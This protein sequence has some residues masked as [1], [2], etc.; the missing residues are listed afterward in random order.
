MHLHMLYRAAAIAGL[1]ALACGGPASAAGAVP[2]RFA[3][4]SNLDHVWTMTA[5]ALVFL[6]QAGFMLLEAGHVRS[7]NSI[8]VAQKNLMDFILSSLAFGAVGFA[9]MFGTSQGG[10]FGWDWNLALFGAPDTWG[11]TFFVFQM[12][13]AGTAATI[14]SGAVAERMTLSGYLWC[15]VLIGLFIY[16]VAGHWSWGGLLSGDEAPFLASWGFMDFAGSTV[17]HSV[18]AWVGLAAIIIIGPRTGKFDEEGRP[19]HL[20]GHSPILS[21]AGCVVLWVGWIGFNGGSTTA[22]TDAFAQIVMNTM[23]AGACGGVI[24]MATGRISRGLYRPEASINGVLGGLVGITAGCDAVSAQGAMAIGLSAG[25]VVVAATWLLENV[26]RLDDPLGAIPVHGFAGAWGTVMTGVFARP[27]AL[28]ADSR[29]E[30]VGVQLVGVG[31]VFAFAFGTAF[32][33][34]KMIDILAGIGPEGGSGLRVSARA[35]VEGLNVTE[36]GALV[37]TTVMQRVLA[38]MAN[39][40]DAEFWPLDID[41]GDE[42]YEMSRHFNQ[43][44]AQ[45]LERREG[46]ANRY[47]EQRGER[48]KV[49]AEIA[50]VVAAAAKGDFDTRLELEGKDGFLLEIARDV[51]ALCDAMSESLTQVH[52][53]LAAAARGDFSTRL[54]G[55]Y[56]GSLEIIQS[57]AN[58][59]FAQLQEAFD[60]IETQVQAVARGTFDG[61]VDLEGKS[62]SIARLC[63][64]INRISEV[65]ESGLGDLFLQLDAMAA[66]DLTGRMAQEHEGRFGEIRDAL[67]KTLGELGAM[68]SEIALGAEEVHAS[69]SAV[70]SSCEEIRTA[71]SDQASVVGGIAE[72]LTEVD[73]TSREHTQ[74]TSQAHRLCDDA[75]RRAVEG[76][77]VARGAVAKMSEISEAGRDIARTVELIQGIARKTHLLSINASVEAAREGHDNAGFR[78]V[79]EEVRALADQTGRAAASITGNTEVVLRV[80]E[81]QE[82]LVSDIAE[83][84]A[85]ME[86]VF[87]ETAE[88]VGS[89]AR[90]GTRQAETISQIAAQLNGLRDGASRNADLAARNSDAVVGLHGTAQRT[91]DLLSTFR[92]AGTAPPL[93]A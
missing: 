44:I 38:K 36:H 57:A 23:I 18:G 68:L 27:E 21:T 86:A 3:L 91:R 50:E 85:G 69:G 48:E 93:A 70:S 28:L 78:V 59:A 53:A 76:S 10:L 84:L 32:L 16:P 13:F 19:R 51:N 9:V 11:I 47:R 58:A 87:S 22:G 34:L 31:I 83:K 89:V 82:R 33:C 7:R 40:P 49:E 41:N 24:G 67:A 6:M 14:V 26:L 25:L 8:N 29:L 75:S 56:Q 4:Q 39:D 61:R 45:M 73:E 17:V 71:S 92:F 15:T 46:E 90:S 2:D 74:R 12:M 81:Q 52:S 35:E 77:E 62:G 63:A 88:I 64:G 43:I 30:Q 37:G 66:G 1:L 55:D 20:D 79:A 60:E 54:T 5:A 80:V 72:K 42:A 65:C